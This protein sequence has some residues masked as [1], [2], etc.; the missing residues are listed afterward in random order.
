MSAY[1]L[2]AGRYFVG[3]PCYALQ[4]DDDAW[5]KLVD[6]F[7]GKRPDFRGGRKLIYKEQNMFWATTAHGDGTYSDQLGHKYGVDAGLLSVV[8]VS[9]AT[10]SLVEM[11]RLGQIVDFPTVF[12][13]YEEDGVIHLGHI[14]I[15]TDNWN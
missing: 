7:H 15:N 9:L 12:V 6:R 1:S 8:P 2:P 14:T 4:G 10:T 3:D 13:C 11:K 5:C